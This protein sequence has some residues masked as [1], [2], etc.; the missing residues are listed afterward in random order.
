MKKN[1]G[2][3]DRAVRLAVAAVI[4]VLY[5]AGVV[6]GTPALILGLVGLAMLFTAITGFCS[7][8]LPFG[9]DTGKC[10]KRES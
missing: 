2:G 8:Y 7:L 5:F 9:I 1:L 10:S 6:D 4:A 3:T